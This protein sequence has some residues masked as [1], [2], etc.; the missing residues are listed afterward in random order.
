MVGTGLPH[1]V[2]RKNIYPD[3]LKLYA[4]QSITKEYPFYVEFQ[5]EKAIDIGGVSR[6]MFSAFFIVGYYNSDE[7]KPA[8][9]T[10]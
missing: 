7:K 1:Y 2:N 9:K 10:L 6:D 4:N 5:G 8:V 3:V